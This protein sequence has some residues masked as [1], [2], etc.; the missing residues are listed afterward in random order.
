M[1]HLSPGYQ[2]D[3]GLFQG[4]FN[5]ELTSQVVTCKFVSNAKRYEFLYHYGAPSHN[6]TAA[7]L[8]SKNDKTVAMFVWVLSSVHM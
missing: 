7:M 6:V 2:C 3:I 5:L 4:K 1:L 8:V